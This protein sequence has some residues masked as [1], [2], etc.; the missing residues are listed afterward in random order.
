MRASIDRLT[1]PWRAHIGSKWTQGQDPARLCA[2]THAHTEP[3][4]A[5]RGQPS[6]T[7]SGGLINAT[8][9]VGDPVVAVVQR[10]NPI[11]GPE[12][13]EDIEAVTAHIAA[14]GLETPRLIR[15]DAGALSV[16]G[17]D[18]GCWRALTWV[19]GQTFHRLDGSERARSAGALVAKWHRAVSDLEYEFVHRRLGVHDTRAHMG[20]LAEA[21]VT[22]GGHRLFGDVEPLACEILGQ[23]A[24]WDGTLELPERVAHGDLKVSNLRFSSTGEALC[25]LDLDTMGRMSVDAELGDAWR[26]WCNPAGEDEASARLDL[27]LFEASA[28]SYLGHH[29]LSS[30]ERDGLVPGV[31]RI[32][33]ELSARFAVDALEER[34][35]GFDP[36]VAPTRGEHNLLRAR[37]QFALA[38][39]VHA[40]RAQME[41]VIRRRA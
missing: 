32:A 27:A 13:H 16:M 2:V 11:F 31:E 38:G 5:L 33:L 36:N 7:L 39:S 26:S 40:Q 28:S 35:F 34:Y 25:L 41:A 14:R 15:T 37:S 6:R 18:G 23:W 10:V 20:R 22:Q 19:A 1:G 4:A 24:R 21:L 8:W 12:V 3:W 30:E 9:T 29:E 17:P